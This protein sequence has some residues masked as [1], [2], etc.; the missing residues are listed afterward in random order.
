M[1]DTFLK[2][3]EKTLSGFQRVLFF[4]AFSG[5]RNE[6]TFFYFSAFTP[7]SLAFTA[8]LQTFN[9]LFKLGIVGTLV[10]MFKKILA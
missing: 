4:L 8:V 5:E 6:G 1:P 10:L 3:A 9:H 7:F 2:Q